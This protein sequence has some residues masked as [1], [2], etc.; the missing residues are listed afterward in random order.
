MLRALSLALPFAALA[1][2]T[3]TSSVTRLSAPYAST[4]VA[5]SGVPAPSSSDWIAGCCS[6][7]TY[8]YWVYATGAPAGSVG[9]QL[10]ANAPGSGC[11]S[12]TLSYYHG[13]SILMSSAP[14]PIDP[15]IQQM[16]LSLTSDPTAMVVDFVSTA[17]GAAPACRYGASVG[18]LT[19]SAPANASAIATIGNVSHALL[20]GLEPGQRVFYACG[21]SAAQSAVYNFTAGALPAAS[22]EGVRVAVFADMGVNDAFGLQQIADDAAAGLFD[23]AIHSGDMA[24]NLESENSANGNFFMNRAMLYAANQPLQPACGNQ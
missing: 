10:F 1:A 17:G 22:G 24:Y 4:R 7:G 19:R 12:L 23:F 11:T 8:F 6:G 15:M 16:R 18:A 2:P 20:E 13:S 9:M 14:I 5:W 21:D 3:I